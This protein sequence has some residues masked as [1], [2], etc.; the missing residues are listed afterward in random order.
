MAGGGLGFGAGF[1]KGFS[2]AL[3]STRE[4]ARKKEAD[5]QARKDRLFGTMLPTLIDNAESWNDVEAAIIAQY[6]EMAG[7]K[8]K[9]AGD[10]PL[11]K[12][13][14]FLAPFVGLK[15]QRGPMDV[16]PTGGQRIGT[17]FGGGDLRV[18][19]GGGGGDAAPAVGTEQAP[20]A[21]PPPAPIFQ[22]PADMPADFLG[23]APFGM[24]PN[25]AIAAPSLTPPAAGA[26]AAGLTPPPAVPEQ[27]LFGVR[28][29]TPEQKAQREATALVNQK[30]AVST[31]QMEKARSVVL[32]AL[33]AI[34][35]TAT[36]Y[37]ALKV[38]GVDIEDPAILAAKRATSTPMLGVDREAIAWAA[39]GKRFL[40]LDREQAAIVLDKEKEMLQSESQA[41][42]TGTAQARFEAP[43][44]I[45]T[46]QN[47]GLPVGTRAA[48]VTGQDVVPLEIKDQRRGL[49][50]LKQDLE[51][52]KG[53][54][55]VLPSQN[56]LAGAAPGAV[57]AVR[58]RM[59]SHRAQVAQ[60]ESI[61]DGMATQLARIKAGQR[62]AQTERDADRAYNAVVALQKGFKDPF[63]GDTRE[64]AEA[65]ITET[66]AGIERVLAGLPTGAVPT[67]PPAQATPPRG[68]SGG[69]PAGA[70]APAAGPVW[71][72]DGKLYVNGQPIN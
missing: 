41:R 8:G 2:N 29:L 13:G 6:P 46:A 71:G 50:V 69:A 36:I 70:P 12:V 49:E 48:D 51:Q 5:E 17:T 40:D 44:D 18:G 3:V 30:A 64:S 67:R 23:G 26:G 59:N 16:G 15:R 60:L 47:A 54:L 34:D 38:M 28:M 27:R 42:G 55:S 35:P 37:S 57:L 24:L 11:S 56:E 63:G 21:A 62:G 58:R 68:R 31:M 65:R 22:P 53:L 7:G 32:P 4:R 20:V 25:D 72:P 10:S 45:P 33:K 14:R 39:Y 52:V 19:R 66:L 1:A 9:K 43:I 61:V